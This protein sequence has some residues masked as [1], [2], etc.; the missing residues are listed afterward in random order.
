MLATPDAGTVGAVPSLRGPKC[1]TAP[2]PRS[3]STVA[4]QPTQGSSALLRVSSVKCAPTVWKVPSSS[5]GLGRQVAVLR[6]RVKGVRTGRVAQRSS[7]YE[8][9]SAALPLRSSDRYPLAPCRP[10]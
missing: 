7:A 3:T 4:Y 10:K 1:V 6:N 5:I 8:R 2:A 9:L